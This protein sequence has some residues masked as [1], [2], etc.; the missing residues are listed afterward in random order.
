MTPIL[1]F[2]YIELAAW[3]FFVHFWLKM[4]HCALY[5]NKTSSQSTQ[6][7]RFNLIITSKMGRVVY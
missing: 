3:Y 6:E 1:A 5:T 4:T 2:R 7:R